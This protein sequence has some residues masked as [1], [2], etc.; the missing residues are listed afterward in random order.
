MTGDD[1][2]VRD[3]ASQARADWE[4]HHMSIGTGGVHR[5]PMWDDGEKRHV[6]A[7]LV[8]H[9]WAHDGFLSPP[10]LD[11]MDRLHGISGTLIHGRLD[12][13]GR[14]IVAWRLHQAWPGSELIIH[15][16]EGHAGEAMV[17]SWCRANTRHTD[18]VAAER[19]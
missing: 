16:D 6:F 14:A 5:D 1:Y 8:T 19:A 18:R 9:C 10:I 17:E 15:E 13:S 11:R 2:R 12:V 4:D 7:T 3:A